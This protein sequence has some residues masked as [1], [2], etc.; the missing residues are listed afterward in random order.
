MFSSA[1]F[2]DR[3]SALCRAHATTITKF[4][5]ETLRLSTSAPTNWKKGTVPSADVVCQA[6]QHWSVSADYLLGLSDVPCQ[7][8]GTPINTQELAF[9]EALH[10]ADPQAQ[11]VALAAAQAVLHASRTTEDPDNRRSGYSLACSFG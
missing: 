1:L 8:V 10:R 2:H 4:A 5:K 9:L 6:A 11:R 3:L 7:I